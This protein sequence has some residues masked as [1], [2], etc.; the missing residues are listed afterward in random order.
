MIYLTSDWHFGHNKEFLYGPRGFSNEFDMDNTIIKNHNAIVNPDDDVYCLGDVMLT[1]NEEGLRCL[2]SLKGKI[3]IIR[4]NHDTDARLELFNNCYNVVEICDAKFLR[5][6]KYHFFL[7]HY[8]CITSNFDDDKPL[9]ARTI[10]LCGH[11][12]TLDRFVDMT[13]GMIYHVEIDAHGCS[14]ISLDYI[15]EDIKTY[16]EKYK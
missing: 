10:N 12:H 9:K 5:Y 11:S 8:P 16:K 14:P 4:G 2:K 7:S 13:K 15:I 6:G 1:N 3:H